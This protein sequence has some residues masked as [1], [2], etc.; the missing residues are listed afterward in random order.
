MV[1]V[2]GILRHD[3]GK[4]SFALELISS[5]KSIGI[6]PYPYKPV[7]GHNAWYQYHTLVNSISLGKLIGEDAYKLASITDRLDEVELISP[8]DLL[9]IPPDPGYYIDRIRTYLDYTEDLERQVVLLRYTILEHGKP[10]SIHFLVEDNLYYIVETLTDGIKEFLDKVGVFEKASR[11]YIL[12]L[13]YSD[14]LYRELDKILYYHRNRNPLVV[15]ESFNNAAAPIPSSL[16]SEYV[17]VV[18]PGRVMV[19][20]G[21]EY[22]R[23]VSVVGSIRHLWNALETSTVIALLKKPILNLPWRPRLSS[24]EALSSKTSDEVASLLAGRR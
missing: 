9:L 13:L 14:T 21:R 8:L 6:N 5:L 24:V 12:K 7:G 16:E 22:A 1:L 15:I 19:Y 2:S 4:T 18:A 11:E 17:V 10:Y 20:D 23:A 3:S